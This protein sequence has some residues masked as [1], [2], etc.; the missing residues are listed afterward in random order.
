M[1]MGIDKI[2][3]AIESYGDNY[4]NAVE[5]EA[6]AEG[7]RN[8][9][10][11]MAIAREDNKERYERFVEEAAHAKR[12]EIARFEAAAKQ[13]VGAYKLECI[14]DVLDEVLNYFLT[15]NDAQFVDV[16]KQALDRYNGDIKPRVHVDAK[17]YEYVFKELGA[18]V[19]I[20]YNPE[21]SN[22]FIL[23]F[24]DY[25]ISFE[26][27]KVFLFN[28]EDYAKNAMHYLFEE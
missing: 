3:Q 7:E 24:N 25:D 13:A 2:L 8:F 18:L 16:L 21:I 14:N 17:H 9:N 23:D 20:I 11:A 1:S 27:E 15:L 22:G 12:R 5:T 26:F 28:R 10:H 6:K 4:C 19:Q